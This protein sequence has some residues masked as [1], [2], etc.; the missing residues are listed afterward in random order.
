[1]MVDPKEIR[2]VLDDGRSPWSE[3]RRLVLRELEQLGKEVENIRMMAGELKTEV[4][5][6]K[7]RASVWGVAAGAISSAVITIGAILLRV[8]G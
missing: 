3:Y 2:R 4:A 7:L 8:L 5:L 6:L 1:M